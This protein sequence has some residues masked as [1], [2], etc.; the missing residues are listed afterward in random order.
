VRAAKSILAAMSFIEEVLR[1]SSV[2][3]IGYWLLSYRLYY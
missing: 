3:I 1:F 2:V